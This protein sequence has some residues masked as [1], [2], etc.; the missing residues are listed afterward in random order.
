VNTEKIREATIMKAIQ[1]HTTATAP[2]CNEKDFFNPTALQRCLNCITCDFKRYAKFND[3]IKK[4]NSHHITLNNQL[5]GIQAFLIWNGKEDEFKQCETTRKILDS[6]K[7]AFAGSHLKLNIW[8]S[9]H[10]T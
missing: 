10:T 4:I 1:N 3:S 9:I 2:V 8:R 7:R 6:L 5:D